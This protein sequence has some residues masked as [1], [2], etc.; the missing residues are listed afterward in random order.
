[1]S[2]KFESDCI[3]SFPSPPRLSNFQDYQTLDENKIKMIGGTVIRIVLLAL[4]LLMFYLPTC[5]KSAEDVTVHLEKYANINISKDVIKAS[6]TSDNNVTYLIKINNTGE[7][8]LK[9]VAVVDSL[10]PGMKYIDSKYKDSDDKFLLRCLDIGEK[11]ETNNVTW[12]LGNL[13]TSQEKVIELNVSKITR[14]AN[15]WGYKIYAEGQALKN[16]INDT[17]IGNAS[18]ARNGLTIGG[19]AL[20]VTMALKDI[21]GVKSGGNKTVYQI[22]VENI[23]DSS[24]DNVTIYDTLPKN[25][26]FL[27]QR[28]ER[29]NKEGKRSEDFSCNLSLEEDSRETSAVRWI[30]G[31]MG[32]GDIVKIILNVGINSNFN[33][34]NSSVRATGEFLDR[35]ISVTTRA[36]DN[37]L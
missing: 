25:T 9:N 15:E 37:R 36:V 22:D 16:H 1:M 20:S 17:E 14:N 8:E 4:V 11:G 5:A 27:G 12:N 32:K 21:N 2:K 24:L 29:R 10:P 7:I 30:F 23:G 19:P 31:N 26:R 28:Y 18:S 34:L 35:R 33:P 6:S 3:T 13:S